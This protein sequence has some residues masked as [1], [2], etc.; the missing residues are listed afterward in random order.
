LTSLKQRRV[1]LGVL[2]SLLSA[3]GDRVVQAQDSDADGLS[4]DREAELGRDPHRVDTDGDYLTDAYELQL[5]TNLN[6]SDSD[7]DGLPDYSEV[8]VHR[9]D[10]L[11][12]DTDGGGTIDGEEVLVEL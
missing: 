3:L 2:F 8:F 6:A 1:V 5:G 10:P 12:K 4:D 9:T 7:A 11:R